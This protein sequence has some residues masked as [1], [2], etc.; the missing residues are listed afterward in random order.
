MKIQG[1]QKS[2]GVIGWKNANIMSLEVPAA[3]NDC[4]MLPETSPMAW[5]NEVMGGEGLT[6]SSVTMFSGDPGI[7]KTTM[8]IQLAD[9]LMKKGFC[10]DSGKKVIVIINTAEES[11]YQMR[12]ACGRVGITT[13][14]IAGQDNTWDALEAHVN[15]VQKEN[16]DA[17]VVVITDSLQTI[18]DGYY[19]D[20]GI[21]S[22]THQRVLEKIVSHAKTQWSTWI[23]I[24]HVTKDGSTS[25]KNTLIHA[26]DAHLTFR[27]DR[28]KNSATYGERLISTTKNRFGSAG[29]V[30]VLGM[31]KT[32]IV[33]KG[34]LLDLETS[35]SEEA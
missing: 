12:K 8:M 4:M 29:I 11:L 23:V 18:D 34:P 21:T 15:K 14:F 2:G 28:K 33:A 17:R 31:T 1:L 13:G 25:G 9:A 30:W 35:D 16:P 26:V 32:G 10:K 24:S 5:M 27:F 6:P 19:K 20:G 22:G 7:G 3:L